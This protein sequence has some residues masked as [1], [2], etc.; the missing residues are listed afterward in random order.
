MFQR[1]NFFKR[2]R[3]EQG[4]LRT[5]LGKYEIVKDLCT[6]ERNKVYIGLDSISG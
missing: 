6:T 1:I 5:R 4:E 3:V 2:N